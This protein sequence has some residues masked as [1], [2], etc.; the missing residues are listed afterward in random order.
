M[1]GMYCAYDQLHMLLKIKS[2][3]S[4]ILVPQKLPTIRYLHVAIKKNHEEIIYM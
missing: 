4:R 1:H 2:K 3:Y